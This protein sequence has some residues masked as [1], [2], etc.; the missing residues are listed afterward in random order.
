MSVTELSDGEGQKAFDYLVNGLGCRDS[1]DKLDCLRHVELEK[2]QSVSFHH[3]V[4]LVASEKKL[5][6]H[7]TSMDGIHLIF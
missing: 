7:L 4:S 5:R 6:G 2:M 1:A 3:A